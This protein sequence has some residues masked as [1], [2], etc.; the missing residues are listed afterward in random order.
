MRVGLVFDL[1]SVYLAEGFGEEETAEFDREDTIEHV[2]SQL[3]A[4]GHQVERVG[5]VR[6]LVSALAQGERWDLVF[7][8]AEGMYGLGR[9]AQVPALLDAYRIPYTFSDPLVC[10]LA[11]HKGM[12]KHV[13]RSLGI[14]TAD[15]CVVESPEDL[16]AVRLPYPLFVKPVA[17]GTGKGIGPR[18]I[19]TSAEALGPACL[20]LLERYDQPVLVETYLPGREYTVGI[21][22]TGASASA[23]GTVEIVLREEAQASAYSYVNKERCEELVLYELAKG[24]IASRCEALALRLWR[25]LGC[26]DAG[27]V[28]LRLDAAGVPNLL[29]VNPLAGLHPD[30]SDLP[31]IGKRVDL[32]YGWLIER[33]VASASARAQ[34]RS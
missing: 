5:H 31:I 13:A 17:E 30:H 21:V 18:S 24:E 9:E 10:A 25:H 22:G 26:R 4:L 34:S 12:T 14:P 11:L 15:F 8:L 3:R 19:I 16:G 2:E 27:R 29:E 7:N 20:E 6:A 28:D 23:V 33:I 32:T 1:R